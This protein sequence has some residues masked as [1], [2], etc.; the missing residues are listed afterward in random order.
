M[1]AFIG[2]IKRETKG[3]TKKHKRRPRGKIQGNVQVSPQGHKFRRISEGDL[4]VISKKV[5]ERQAQQETYRDM[6]REI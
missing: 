1:K 2:K 6:S 3:K 4:S 5:A